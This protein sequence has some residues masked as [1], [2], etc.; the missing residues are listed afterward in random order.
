VKKRIVVVGVGALGSHVVQ[1]VR[2]VEADI[3]AIDFDR[4]EQKNVLSQFHSK[5]SVGKNKAVALKDAVGFLFGVRIEAFP[6]KLV[7]VNADHHLRAADL[8]I[9]CLDNAAG[10]NLIQSSV[11]ANGV[12]CL[13]AALDAAGSFGR[14]VWDE[15]FHADEETPG[16][17]TCEDG[18]FLPFVVLVASHAAYAA[19][20]FLL[21]GRKLGFSVHP[22]GST[23]T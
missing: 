18:A 23:R 19:Q 2:N 20:Q 1:F 15:A 7:E 3:R 13:H 4:V 22:G 5:P 11:R 21:T 10:R 8:V 6:H 16:A 17:A 14:V 9:D 12:P